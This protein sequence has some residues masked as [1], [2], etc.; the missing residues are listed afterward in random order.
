MEN[1]GAKGPRFFLIAKDLD[2]KIDFK[3]Q[4]PYIFWRISRRI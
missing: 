4:S 3:N 1:A 2:D